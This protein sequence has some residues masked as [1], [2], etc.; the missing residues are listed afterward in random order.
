MN[1]IAVAVAQF[2]IAWFVTPYIPFPGVTLETFYLIRGLLVGVV[3]GLVGFGA[4]LAMKDT[5]RPAA[6][7]AAIACALLVAIFVQY[8]RHLGVDFILNSFPFW[9]R[10]VLIVFAAV[11]GYWAAHDLSKL[12]FDP[13]IPVIVVV[14]IFGA[15]LG[16]FTG[17]AAM[18]AMLPPGTYPRFLIA[19]PILIG[20]GLGLLLGGALVHAVMYPFRW[21]APPAA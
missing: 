12:P 14:A 16:A 3:V 11:C 17:A 2:A 21:R 1:W 4:A 6:L 5:P 20:G 10:H 9:F 15:V 7:G 8:A 18:Y 13:A 19:I